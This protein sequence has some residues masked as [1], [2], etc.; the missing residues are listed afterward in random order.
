MA[1]WSE[2]Q[3]RDRLMDAFVETDPVNIVLHRPTWA[4]TAAGGRT[5]AGVDD[6]AEQRFMIYPFK[7]RL[8]VESRA[9]PQSYGEEKVEYIH[10]IIIFKRDHDIQVDDF[11]DP[12]TDIVPPTDR[13]EP[14]RYEVVFLSAR[15]WDRGQ[16]GLLYRG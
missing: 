10:W 13:W 2:Q 8:T 14:G 5:Q 15:A 3:V 6:L 4:A 9:N 11:F 16:A 7:R 1:A 12:A